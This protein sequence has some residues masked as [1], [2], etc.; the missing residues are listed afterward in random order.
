MT[1]CSTRRFGALA[2]TAT[3]SLA[4]LVSGFGAAA[5]QSGPPPTEER[6][7][8]DEIPTPAADIAE[9]DGWLAEY[10]TGAI[11]MVRNLVPDQEAL[12]DVERRIEALAR[13]QQLPAAEALFRAAT[14]DPELP[15]GGGASANALDFEAELLP[16]R[17]RA[18]A[19]HAIAGMQCEGLDAW[20]LERLDGRALAKDPG[21]RP[22]ADAA[23]RILGERG[24]EPA[25]LALERALGAF[26]KELRVAAVDVLAETAGLDTIDVFFDL[27][28]DRQPEVRI[29]AVRGIT[30][31][32]AP[33]TDETD[34][35]ASSVPEDIASFREKAL[36]EFE[37]ILERDKIW[38]VRAAAA[39]CTARLR[40]KHAV[41]V[42]IAGYEAE[43]KRKKEPWAMDMRLHRLLSGMTGQNIPP[44]DAKP[45][46]AFWKDAG[47]GFRIV[48]DPTKASKPNAD[49][50]YD[51]FFSLDLQS[52]RVLFVVDLS[53]S[54]KE[55]ITL[56]TGTTTTKA[57]DTTTKIRLVLDEL[58]RIVLSLPED[59]TFN[60]VVFNDGVKVW[61]ETRD[62]MP[63][64][65]KLDDDAR[66]DLL[67][68]FLENLEPRGPTNLH[69]ALDRALGF[70]NKGLDDER[71]AAAFDTIY[72]LT[73]G[74][75]SYGRVTDKDEIRRLVR[76]TNHLKRLTI[77]AI[78]FG[79][80]NDTEFLKLLAEENGG[81]HV[82]VE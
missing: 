29:L 70:A 12:G 19:R 62:G 44:G 23:L 40:T 4:L 65:V 30:S 34:A 50:R 67:G 35:D 42:L 59:S 2:S 27:L 14:V 28:G 31:A 46:K 75:P 54:M 69:G 6:A 56:Q 41:P 10:R 76:E 1:D 51:R 81:R 45:W 38:Q 74:A 21:L 37:H 32:L 53:G 5:A 72:V 3:W 22:L 7:P 82:H 61:R 36:K 8:G 43:L 63:A 78:T 25:K 77:H 15:G 52:D 33:H 68:S 66:D 18:M 58:R 73:D 11:R 60:V 80:K 9:F 57:G 55:D 26:P 47:P 48:A 79:A 20:L 16:W 24:G 71:Y 49:P 64:A 13:W 17:V 39:D